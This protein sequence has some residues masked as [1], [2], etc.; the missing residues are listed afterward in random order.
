MSNK[1]V[2]GMRQ[3][4][5][6]GR[7][8]DLSQLEAAVRQNASI[9]ECAILQKQR[10]GQ[11]PE[12]VVYVV[13]S[14][15]HSAERI[16][17]QV[18]S[19]I[20]ADIACSSVLVASMPMTSDGVVDEAALAR[21]P[22][23]D[24]NLV[25]GWESRLRE[26]PEI[27]QAAVV[28]QDFS[29]EEKPLHLSDLI[30]GW[31]PP[32]LQDDA[33][34]ASGQST[35]A[36]KES[37]PRPPAYAD[38]GPLTI[39][40]DAPKTFT[41]AILQ[42]A[43][44]FP[45]KGILH[46]R[47][48]GEEFFQSYP[49]L[50]EQAKRILAG[51]RAKG[52]QP[53]DRVVLQ[54]ELLSD[55]FAA[56]WACVL[57][58]ITPVNVA[59]APSYAERNSIVNK[60]Y[61]IWKLL[62]HPVVIASEHL[63]QPLTAL[64]RFF[65]GEGFNV[66]SVEE[67]KRHQPTE[68]IY[69]S[70]PE[71]LVFFQLT[72]G[73]TGVP[74]CIQ[75]SHKSVIAH[76][77]GSG[78]FNGYTADDVI[79]NWL[80]V[81]HVVPTLTCNLK[82]VYM[83]C[84]EVQVA[85]NV[86]IAE[87]LRWLD[88]M[89]RHKVTHSWAPNFGFKLVADRLASVEGKTWNLSHVKFLMNAGEQVTLPVV[90][91]F[92][93]RTAP[94]GVTPVMMQPSFGMAEACTCMTYTNDFSFGTPVHRF[95]KSTLSGLLEPSKT[96]DA[97]TITFIDLGPPVPGVEIRITDAENK[98]VP[99]GK[100]GRFQIKGDVITRGYLYNDAANKEAFVGD[101]WFNSG[102]LGYIWNGRLALTGREK[103][104]IIIRGANF[105]CYEIEDVVNTLPGAQPTFTAAVSVS[106]PSS[107]SES[108]GIF[109]VPQK[110]DME[111]KVRLMEQ[112][113]K[114]VA[115]NLG[116]SPS[117][118]V[119]LPK[120]EFCKTTSG[121]IQRNQMKKSLMAGQ[122]DAIL[123]E[124]DVTLK[125]S[126]TVPAWFFEVGWRQKQLTPID[127]AADGA[128]VIFA[129]S[130]GLGAVLC[131]TLGAKQACVRV[132]AGAEF[133]KLGANSY[134]I[135]P[136]SAE[137]YSRLMKSL[138]DDGVKISQ[139]FHLFT[140]GDYTASWV[141]NNVEQSLNLGTYSLLFLAQALGHLQESQRPKRLVV[142][143]SQSQHVEA[144]DAIDATR[145]MVRALVKTIPQ[146]MS[147]LV[148]NHV[149]LEG[150]S[151]A[152]DAEA[153]AAEIS[154]AAMDRE[155][156]WRGGKRWVPTL[157]RA[158]A[159][160]KN[161]IAFKKNALYVLT[162]GLGGVG[163]QI[164]KEL[165]KNHGVRLLILGRTPLPDRSTWQDPAV[166]KGLLAERIQAYLDLENW[167]EISYEALD[168]SNVSALQSAVQRATKL[169]SCELDGVVHVAG[170]YQE[171]LLAE[172]T[173]ESFARVLASKVHGT[174][175]LHQLLK[176]R[177]DALFISFSSVNGFFGGFSVGAYAAANAFVDFLAEHQRQMGSPRSRSFA[178][179]LWDETGMSRGFGMKQLA[180]TR[181]YYSIG[182]EQGLHSFLAVLQQDGA[183]I[184]IGLD[185]SK[186]PVRRYI[187]ETLPSLQ[188][189]SAYVV[190][191]D[192][193]EKTG[194]ESLSVPDRFGNATRCTFQYLKELPLTAT[195]DV[196]RE[197]LSQLLQERAAGEREPLQTDVERALAGVWTEVLG[198]EKVGRTDNF[199]DLGG[200]SLS[201]VQIT[202]KIQQVFQVDLPLK[203]FLEAP[204]LK[205]QAE[206]LERELL[207]QAD[208]G[209]L[210]QLMKEMES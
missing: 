149:D 96:E 31:K 171:R 153:L 83:G 140:Y 174:L 165:L 18:R 194:L 117:V 33:A 95:L 62:E 111:E 188:Q 75:E 38:G 10:N 204:V 35:E 177:P 189:L 82:D 4:V 135:N 203:T 29:T 45:N 200:H 107:G 106:D 71:D 3:S 121:K 88:L 1:S 192:G 208:A 6:Q 190:T 99:E 157:Q 205:A 59:V 108:L 87:P 154:S 77:H 139:M 163:L 40:A 210:E 67:L 197:R 101:G 159:A 9:E 116:I 143:S 46:V 172:E 186:S 151:P 23:L 103:E 84:Q 134:R 160:A 26:L 37:K 68:N 115:S 127:V 61:N 120:S 24:S 55:H 169:W 100:I 119:P 156:A 85:T 131:E 86:V 137:D 17:A 28:V 48:N 182:R 91:E 129:D 76:I 54:C 64:E 144:G 199:F 7:C 161:P 70:K 176:D 50:L 155:S 201:A 109:F 12:L 105:Y 128:A 32:A 19:S 51:L 11:S 15:P 183:H 123:K 147:W 181:G 79:L 49:A 206:H 2:I 124:I 30:P 14:F 136:A 90:A 41:E 93:K 138:A 150:K 184:L 89:E 187:D 142:A 198:V 65:P 113:R 43:K 148:C 132:E 94:F 73:S 196:C 110:E 80:P 72:S 69:P 179:S 63:V 16:E 56:F 152:T 185:S 130:K 21:I 5:L 202:F 39:P 34:I 126:N 98:V 178:W 180:R 164:A 42:T 78:Q 13:P 168:I 166:H 27:E 141:Q 25:Q 145:G 60:L 47:A 191:R 207:A 158:H 122:Y 8:I 167:G 66:Q 22:M 114:S 102:D 112:I 57:G 81:D 162:G 175:A 118:I 53:G 125:N 146:E 209:E 195:G 52:M 104:M 36:V 170:V 173:R 20:P 97:T 133:A 193:G 74:K 92:L 58:G 44:K